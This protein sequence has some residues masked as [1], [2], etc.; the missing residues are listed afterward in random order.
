V[1]VA[2]LGNGAVP[3]DLIDIVNALCVRSSSTMSATATSLVPD[4]ERGHDHG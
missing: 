3:V 2:A 1:T 4:H